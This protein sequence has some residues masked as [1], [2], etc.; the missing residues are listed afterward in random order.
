MEKEEVI[1]EIKRKIKEEEDA[2]GIR[3]IRAERLVKEAR[4][5]SKKR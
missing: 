5:I 1:E 4:E 2:S 3:L